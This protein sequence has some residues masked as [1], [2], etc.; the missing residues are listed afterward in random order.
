VTARI[1]PFL[2]KRKPRP[3]QPEKRSWLDGGGLTIS[4]KVTTPSDPDTPAPPP[5]PKS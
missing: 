5:P 1:L 2:F 4:V 3:P